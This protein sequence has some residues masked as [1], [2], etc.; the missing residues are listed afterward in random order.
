MLI[1]KNIEFKIYRAYNK[2]YYFVN[3]YA[4][5]TRKYG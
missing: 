3:H 4:V 5:S 1:Y 2:N